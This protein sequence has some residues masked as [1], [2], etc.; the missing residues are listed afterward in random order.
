MLDLVSQGLSG[1]SI[2]CTPTVGQWTQV[3]G[4]HDASSH[5]E[6]FLLKDLS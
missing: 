3:R 1:V 5:V 2:T 4:G 6:S